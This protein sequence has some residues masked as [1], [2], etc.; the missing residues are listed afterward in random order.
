[1]LENNFKE[2]LLIT[3]YHKKIFLIPGKL[4]ISV[5]V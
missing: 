3:G 5:K 1:M 4:E 2:K